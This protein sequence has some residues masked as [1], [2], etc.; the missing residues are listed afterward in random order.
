MRPF[1]TRVCTSLWLISPQWIMYIPIRLIYYFIL[2][3]LISFP[4]LNSS[5]QACPP[6][7]YA[8]RVS[9]SSLNLT[10]EN[11]VLES[12][13]S[14]FQI[15]F[16]SAETQYKFDSLSGNPLGFSN[17]M[18]PNIVWIVFSIFVWRGSISIFDLF[19]GFP[20]LVGWSR[21]SAQDDL[22]YAWVLRQNGKR[23]YE[24]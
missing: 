1:W 23:L 2:V 8:E 21:Q 18:C 6:I 9:P 16:P 7:V 11:K 4:D 24:G 14:A 3:W 10:R 17:T 5:S 19:T 22:K 12:G 13:F 15:V 20:L